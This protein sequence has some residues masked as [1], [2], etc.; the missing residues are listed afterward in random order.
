MTYRLFLAICVTSTL[1]GCTGE[2]GTGDGAKKVVPVA[3]PAAQTDTAAKEQAEAAAD[4]AA[5]AAREQ[6]RAAAD[7]VADTSIDKTDPAWKQQL[8][9]PKVMTFEVGKQ[10]YWDMETNM[11]RMSFRL[12]HEASPMH[13]TSTVYLTELGF[14]DDV[15]FHRVIK[16]FMAQGGD[17]TGT[18]RGGPGYNYDGEFG[19]GLVHDRPG[20]LSMANAGAGT[21]GSQ[22]FITFVP[23]PHLNGKHTIFGEL[24]S[25]EDTLS[26][27]EQ[28]GSR[29]GPTTERLEIIS[30][31]IRTE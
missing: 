25:G 6:A 28:R 13:V 22:F 8:K 7:A 1:L 11:G 27:L 23:T 15:I 16:G 24:V 19:S 2:S 17:P 21:D 14:Y 12:F 30:A 3:E 20:L 10:Y 5:A 18:G 26:A 31:T 29:R 4:A 9:A